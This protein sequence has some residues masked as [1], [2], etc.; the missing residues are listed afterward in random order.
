MEESTHLDQFCRWEISFTLKEAIQVLHR[1]LTIRPAMD[2]RW[3]PR[4][5]KHPLSLLQYLCAENK[6]FFDAY[7]LQYRASKDLQ[8]HDKA[9]TLK[10]DVHQKQCPVAKTERQSSIDFSNQTFFMFL[11]IRPQPFLSFADDLQLQD[12]S[13]EAPTHIISM[14]HI[15]RQTA[16]FSPCPRS[17]NSVHFSPFPVRTFYYIRIQAVEQTIPEY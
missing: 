14:I 5:K 15:F 12:H 2:G 17:L 11:G 6:S 13:D 16:V 4:R 9:Q 1:L 10:R 8:T 7:E 3:S